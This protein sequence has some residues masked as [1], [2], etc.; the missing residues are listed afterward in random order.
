MPFVIENPAYGKPIEELPVTAELRA[1]HPKATV[2]EVFQGAALPQLGVPCYDGAR[3]VYFGDGRSSERGE[4]CTN[5]GTD[6]SYGTDLRFQLHLGGEARRTLMKFDLGV[7]PA[8]AT[9]AKA[10]LM[11]NVEDLNPK[12]DRAVRVIALRK[13]WSETVVGVMG[14]LNSTLSPEPAPHERKYPVG[15]RENWEE[16]LYRGQGDSHPGTVATASLDQKGWNALDI[17]LAARNWVGGLWVNRGVAIEMANEEFRF[18]THDIRMT[19]SDYPVDPRLRPRLILVLDGKLKPVPHQVRER[20]ADLRAALARAKAAGKPVL[21]NVLSAASLTSRRFETQV[22]SSV[23]AVGKFIA[24][25]FIEV[26]L[27]AD[28]PEHREFLQA[29][30]VRRFPT[31]LILTSEGDRAAILEPFDWDTPFGLM[32]SAFEFE[33]LYTKALADALARLA[34]GGRGR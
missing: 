8:D 6:L 22:L 12:A 28:S 21:V 1:E 16:P 19:A 14:G 4:S 23:P 13:R 33:Q 11:L 30:G 26:R 10:L 31:A 3:D 24:Q 27:D 29:H 17:T 2:V 34:S 32:R 9:V 25:H 20:N 5:R 18:G 7:L 15:D